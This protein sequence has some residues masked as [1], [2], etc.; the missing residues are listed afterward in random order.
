MSIFEERELWE[1]FRY[2]F[3]NLDNY[4]KGAD[5]QFNTEVAELAHVISLL[6]VI[7]KRYSAVLSQEEQ[8]ILTDR[9]EAGVSRLIMLD[10]G[11]LLSL[12]YFERN[13]PGNPDA[14]ITRAQTFVSSI[15]P[16][17][18]IAADR[19]PMDGTTWK[20]FL[21]DLSNFTFGL[22]RII[23]KSQEPLKGKLLFLLVSVIHST[24]SL[25]KTLE[26]VKIDKGQELLIKARASFKITTDY[27]LKLLDTG[28][29]DN[30]LSSS[31]GLALYLNRVLSED[32][33]EAYKISFAPVKALV[34][35]HISQIDYT[36]I[37]ERT[38][39]FE[40][41]NLAETGAPLPA[42]LKVSTRY[43]PLAFLASGYIRLTN[44]AD[45]L[46]VLPIKD[47]SSEEVTVDDINSFYEVRKIKNVP[48][49]V[50]PLTLRENF[51]KVS[52]G[53]IIG[54]PF[55]Q[56]DWGG[57]FLDLFSNRVQLNKGRVNSAFMFKGKGL[58][59]KLTLAHCGKNG[60]QILRLFK[61]PAKVY[62]IQ[63]VNEIDP[64]VREFTKIISE[65]MARQRGENL[66]Y[67]FI[68]G[69]DTYRVL[70]AYNRINDDGSE[71]NR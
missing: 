17:F 34:D 65:T 23:E 24:G 27:L 41:L 70:R 63:H 57:E 37:T 7:S 18:E 31:P 20:Y 38:K 68:D 3:R 15:R 45:F 59:T 8:T 44:G 53:E 9:I 55:V 28:E 71:I 67:C 62:V 46:G 30:Y 49:N 35:K 54:E 39:S 19:V 50:L 29:L 11:Y 21:R 36:K 42:T 52:F 13:Y 66:H 32:F 40:V 6:N 5:F 48:A 33:P 47:G 64:S 2:T 43:S 60:D 51:I 1:D 10:Q 4:L 61:I 69:A 26:R 16:L 25:C 12:Y 58:K 56:K 22:K 14:A